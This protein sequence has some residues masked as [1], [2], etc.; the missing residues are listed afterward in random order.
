[1]NTLVLLGLGALKSYRGLK[2][3]LIAGAVTLLLLLGLA[4]WA[5]V[6]AFGWLS[7][8]IPVATQALKDR[9]PEVRRQVE[10]VVPNMTQ[11]VDEWLPGTTPPLRD[12]PGEDPGQLTRYEGFVRTLYVVQ[13][14]SR[15]AVYEGRADF[16]SVA[17]HYHARFKEKGWQHRVL[18]AA[19]NEERHEYR[20]QKMRYE[21]YLK[22]QNGSVSVEIAEFATAQRADRATA[23]T[24]RD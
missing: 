1:M 17:E 3:I 20:A 22:Q 9:V 21:L 12:V 24:T 14:D 6:A 7:N 16:R 10:A 4:I 19:A 11:A 18:F 5:A 2:T 8:Q 15:K 23:P 13:D